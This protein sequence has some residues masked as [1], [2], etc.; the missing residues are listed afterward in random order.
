MSARRAFFLL[1]GWAVLGAALSPPLDAAADRSL[2]AHMAQHMLLLA[3]V[4]PLLLLG[5]PVRVAL[6]LLPPR[7]ARRLLVALHRRP[8]ARVAGP[9]FA[10]A[11]FAAVVVCLHLPPAYDAAL[12]SELLHAGEHLAYLLAGLLLWAAAMGSDPQAR[13]LSAVAVV[14]L[15]AAAMVP[16]VAVGVALD[17]ASGVVYSPYAARAGIAGAIAEQGPA[18]TVMWAG[19]L[20]FAAAIVLAGW[21]AV[22]REERRQRLRET[23]AA[24]SRRL[25]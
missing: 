18:A 6:E 7:W 10:L 24:S 1:A 25:P 23:V 21:A 13:P 19:D 11:L 4:P 5:E 14:G 8:L 9:G 15:L 3:V 17:T 20:P 12:E 22:R 2:P 16:M